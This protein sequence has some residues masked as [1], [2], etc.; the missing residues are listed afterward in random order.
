[1]GDTAGFWSS[2]SAAKEKQNK[3]EKKSPK[4]ANASPTVT[5]AFS[6]SVLPP[7]HNTAPFHPI[8]FTG[9][10][11]PR[12]HFNPI[13]PYFAHYQQ[14]QRG[15]SFFVGFIPSI[16]EQSPATATKEHGDE[17][18]EMWEGHANDAIFLLPPD[19]RQRHR[20]R[21]QH[22]EPRDAA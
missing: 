3:K 15:G 19:V 14:H 11:H 13:L 7:L 2:A 9:G 16:G 6:V 5:R 12:T 22:P 21:R 8:P 10:T 1:V 17:Q 4:E 18:G 20:S